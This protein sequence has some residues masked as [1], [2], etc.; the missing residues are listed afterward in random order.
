MIDTGFKFTE[1]DFALVSAGFNR[2]MPIR[3]VQV[4]I[5][6][7]PQFDEDN[8]PVMTEYTDLEWI[9]QYVIGQVMK[10]ATK[11]WR[12]LT[13]DGNPMDMERVKQIKANL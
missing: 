11:G 3:N 2:D 1:E 4:V 13:L 10:K 6:D 7:V 8:K 12:K 5:D 9:R